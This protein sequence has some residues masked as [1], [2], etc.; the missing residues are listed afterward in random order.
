[1]ELKIEGL[2]ESPTFTEENARKFETETKAQRNSQEW[3]D[4]RKFRITA[5]LF[6]VV[7]RLKVKSSTN[8][9]VL[10]ILGTKQFR[11]TAAMSGVLITR[12]MQ[13]RNM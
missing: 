5:S 10:Q 6:G 3:F 9:I 1:M 8:T 13:C 11:L 4:A 12:E 7:K 2:R